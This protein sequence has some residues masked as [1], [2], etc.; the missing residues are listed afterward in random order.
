MTF[1]TENHHFIPDGEDVID[2]HVDGPKE[3]TCMQYNYSHSCTPQS[4]SVCGDK[5]TG[6]LAVL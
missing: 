5:P 1:H 6:I 3:F 2:G 4:Q